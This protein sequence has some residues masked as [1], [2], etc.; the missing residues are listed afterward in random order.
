[1]TKKANLLPT[2]MD[3]GLVEVG[4]LTEVKLPVFEVVWLETLDSAT[5]SV[6]AGGVKAIVLKELVN[7]C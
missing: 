1:V 3:E 4:G 6:T 2:M 7:D 5:Q